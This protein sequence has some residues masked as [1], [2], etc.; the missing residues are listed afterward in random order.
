M[1]WSLLISSTSG[2]VVDE[3]GYDS[4]DKLAVGEFPSVLLKS[5]YLVKIDA[6]A[7]SKAVLLKNLKLSEAISLEFNLLKSIDG[8][9]V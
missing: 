2:Y 7:L 8:Y 3:A 1:V 6:L 5:L 9:F 4:V